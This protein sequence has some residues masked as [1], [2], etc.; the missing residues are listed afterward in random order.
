MSDELTTIDAPEIPGTLAEHRAEFPGKRSRNDQRPLPSPEREPSASPAPKHRAKSQQAGVGDVETIARLTKELR[1]AEDAVTIDRQAGESERTYALR[2]RIEIAK[3]ATTPAAPVT[4]APA[5]AAPPASAAPISSAPVPQSAPP[6]QWQ[7]PPT[8]FAEPEPPRA[9]FASEGEYYRALTAWDRRKERFEESIVQRDAQ[10]RGQ[11]QIF[12]REMIAGMQ[13]HAQKITTF[14]KARPDIKAIFDAEAAKPEAE[15][16][17]ITLA[18]RGAIEFHEQGPE[19]VVALIQHPDLADELFLLTNGR[20][21]GDPRT[22]S[23][24]ATVRRRLLQRVAA[25]STGA[26]PSPRRPPVTAPHPP[27][28]VR[29]ATPTP[30]DAPATETPGSLRE[31]R[32]QF[33]STRPRH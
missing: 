14:A 3:R 28:P 32:H 24:V 31:H 12:D 22:D 5:A 7:P 17:Q 29:T 19:M 1:A 4:A 25:V 30:R 27:T 33:P 10:L 15:Q 23:L 6:Q 8:V 21:V 26:A 18:M 13:T 16:I 2:K 9:S 11:Q 20:P